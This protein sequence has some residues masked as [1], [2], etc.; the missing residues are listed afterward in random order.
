MNGAGRRRKSR[1]EGRAAGSKCL[2]PEDI[3]F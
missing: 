3:E 2:I 1:E